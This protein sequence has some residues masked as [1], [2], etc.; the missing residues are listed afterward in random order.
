MNGALMVGTRH[1]GTWRHL[2][3]WVCATLVVA[4]GWLVTPAPVT[5]YDGVGQPDE[6]YRYVSAPPGAKATVKKATGAQASLPI[7][8]GFSV[9]D[10]S[11]DSKESGPQ[12]SVLLPQG[13]LAAPGETVALNLVPQAPAEQPADGRIDGNVYRLSIVDAAG[14]VTFVPGTRPATIYLRST[15]QRQPGPVMEHR[16]GPGKK[17][18]RMVTRRTGLDYYLALVPDAGEYAMVF[19]RQGTPTAGT[20]SAQAPGDPGSSRGLVGA[21]LLSLV[22][23]LA[24][25][26]AVRL[27]AREP[28]TK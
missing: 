20:A 7:V 18:Q 27:R 23:L 16:A 8:A 21:L 6:P 14:P 12:A 5:V 10:G 22:L 24:A 13:T 3:W 1:S 28:E 2:R 17:W 26:L 19:V 15:T 25:V 4:V 9:R 11:L